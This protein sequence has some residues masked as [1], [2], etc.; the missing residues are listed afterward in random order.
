MQLV[1]IKTLARAS[2][3]TGKIFARSD[4]AW[5]LYVQGGRLITTAAR[6]VSPSYI[7]GQITKEIVRARLHPSS[8]ILRDLYDLGWQG[9][10][11]AEANT[12]PEPLWLDDKGVP[13]RI[14]CIA[15]V[16]KFPD[17][18]IKTEIYSAL[19]DLEGLLPQ[20]SLWKQPLSTYHISV[21]HTTGVYLGGF[22][23]PEIRSRGIRL[24]DNLKGI[25]SNYPPSRFHVIGL[26]L[27]RIGIIIAKVF[28][29]DDRILRIRSD[30]Q[31]KDPAI[32][33]QK[34]VYNLTLGR[35]YQPLSKEVWSKLRDRVEDKYL[36]RYFG[37]LTLD[38]LLAFEETMAYNNSC[39]P[40]FE[41]RMGG[42]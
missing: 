40:L 9:A 1:K 8:D 36:A 22:T 24:M 13:K 42:R 14:G 3:I 10:L 20:N 7:G 11:E 18:R 33:K 12:V 38:T 5:G 19:Q 29:E 2:R 27:N 4:Q 6:Q 34:E 35:I 39:I 21:C 30:F 26:N 16:M 32:P 15:A 37:A 23:D 17:G 31:K 41:V 28:S 25:A